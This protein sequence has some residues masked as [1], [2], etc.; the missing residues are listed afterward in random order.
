VLIGRHVGLL[1][2][3]FGELVARD[4]PPCDTKQA[5]VVSPQKNLKKL[6]FAGNDAPSNVFIAQQGHFGGAG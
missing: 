5:L 4:D 2:N 6:S 1:N 3:I